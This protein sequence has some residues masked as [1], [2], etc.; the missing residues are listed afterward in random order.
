MKL[1]AD[2][3]EIVKTSE[4]MSGH[5]WFRLGGPAEYFVRPRDKSELLDVVKRCH[6]NEVMVHILG[7]GS[8]ILV[9]DGGVRGVVIQLM[10]QHFG[11]VEIEGTTVRVG[12][13]AGLTKV[14]QKCARE[15][16][17]GMECLTGIPGSIGG[18]VKMPRR[19]GSK[20][21]SSSKR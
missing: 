4:P 2:L 14:I 11:G 20:W 17:S 15:G 1:F 7:K 8:N 5:I 3:E 9:A 18:A 21:A 13:G 19:Q 12:A 16:L 10:D 6:E